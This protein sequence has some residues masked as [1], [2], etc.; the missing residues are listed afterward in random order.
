[1]ADVLIR[2]IDDDDLRLIDSV[3]ARQ[4]LSRSELLRRETHEFARRHASES[5]TVD[6]LRQSLSLSQ[7]LL[8]EDVMR[9]AWE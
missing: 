4:G 7:D 1:M 8:D 9:R 2:N 6:D 3:A 5:V